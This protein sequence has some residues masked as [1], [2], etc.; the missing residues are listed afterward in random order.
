M[1]PLNYYNHPVR[2]TNVR[3]V[4]SVKVNL[5]QVLDYAIYREVKVQLDLIHC[6][7]K[8]YDHI[9]FFLDVWV[10]PK[11]CH[12]GPIVVPE[13]CHFA[14]FTSLYMIASQSDPEH[15]ISPAP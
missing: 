1:Q 9:S 3:Y 12:K 13:I 6:K 2:V 15:F 4:K 8:S 11:G 14:G 7:G 10:F 5:Y